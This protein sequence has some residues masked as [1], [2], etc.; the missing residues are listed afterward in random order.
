MSSGNEF[1]ALVPSD[2]RELIPVFLENSQKA[3][4]SLIQAIA[5]A[6]FEM[7]RL[8]GHRMKGSGNSYGFAPISAIGMEI[9]ETAKRNDKTELIR[10]A[11]KYRH[12]LANVKIRY[13]DS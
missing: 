3:F 9:E 1:E 13:Q 10:L 5:A 2:L 11:A 7:V 8:I 12:Y 4:Q 6:D